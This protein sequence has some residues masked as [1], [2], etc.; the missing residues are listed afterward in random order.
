MYSKKLVREL[1]T[2][3]PVI[4]WSFADWKFEVSQSIPQFYPTLE[5]VWPSVKLVLPQSTPATYTFKLFR[6]LGA[7]LNK[8]DDWTC[9]FPIG[10]YAEVRQS[11]EEQFGRVDEIGNCGACGGTGWTDNPLFGTVRC[12]FCNS[13]IKPERLRVEYIGQVRLHPKPFG[14]QRM[15][16]VCGGSGTHRGTYITCTNCHGRGTEP[17]DRNERY[18]SAW[19]NG[20]WTVRFPEEVL[21]EFFPVAEKFDGDFY[22]ALLSAPDLS[23]AYKKFARQYH[24]DL[25]PRGHKQFLKLREAYENLQDPMRRKRYEAGLKFQIVTK[26]ES[27]FKPPKSCGLVTVEMDYV[28]TQPTLGQSPWSRGATCDKRVAV[29]TKILS[30]EDIYD[31]QG[32]MMCSTWNFEG[33]ARTQYRQQ[34]RS[35]QPFTIT[36]EEVAPEFDIRI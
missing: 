22:K 29:V 3:N 14:S 20:D 26:N 27:L 10:Y 19:V 12:N 21:K 9:T 13:T 30:W 35:I 8:L 5:R 36:W 1:C 24:P 33:S 23:K 7:R 15:C 6:I 18:A 32:R 16:R 4:Y 31:S 2:K 11:L 17:T 25:N 28:E 34:Q